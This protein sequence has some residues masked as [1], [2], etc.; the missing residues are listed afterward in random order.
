MNLSFKLLSGQTFSLEFPA[1]VT[2]R[3]HDIYFFRLSLN[4]IFRSINLSHRFFAPL[5][6]PL[7]FFPPNQV[8]QVKETI[9]REKDYALDGMKLLFAGAILSDDSK[10]ITE[11]KVTTGNTLVLMAKKAKWVSKPK[12][13]E[14]EK[15]SQQ[16]PT[17]QKPPVSTPVAPKPTEQPQPQPQQPE[18]QPQQPEAQPPQTASAAPASTLVAGDSY[19]QAIAEMMAMGFERERVEMCMRMAFNNPD[20]A[21]EYLIS[22][23][24]PEVEQQFTQRAQPQEEQG[25]STE[26]IDSELYGGS[27]SDMQDI[28]AEEEGMGGTGDMD[29]GALLEQ[30]PHFNQLRAAVQANPNLLQPVM[31]QLAQQSPELLQLISQNPQ[32]FVRLLNEPPQQQPQQQQQQQQ[33]AFGNI[34]PELAA[35]LLGAGVGGGGAGPRPGTITVTPEEAGHID[36]LMQLGF[37]RGTAAQAYFAC[38][39]DMNAAAD[40]LLM[41]MDEES[42]EEEEQQQQ[43]GGGDSAE[44]Q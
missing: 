5:F 35:A 11:S 34:P 18:T 4:T 23:I 39:K 25:Q 1:D 8:G 7:F 38:D 33:G 28:L 36:Q 31:Q 17:E 2:V 32:E 16:Q 10:P 21:A 44:Q 20:R 26:E 12:Q 41:M 42:A 29:L 6:F 14:E 30:I 9:A 37:D 22:G 24:P 43:G 15:P 3:Y 19:N 13:E 27:E 40:F